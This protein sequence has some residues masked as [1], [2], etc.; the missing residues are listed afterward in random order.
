VAWRASKGSRRA[1]AWSCRRDALDDFRAAYLPR[2][3]L[4][5]GTDQALNTPSPR[6]ALLIFSLSSPIVRTCQQHA[7]AAFRLPIQRVSPTRSAS[8]PDRSTKLRHSR[9]PS[10][11]GADSL[12]RWL[13]QGRA[14]DSGRSSGHEASALGGETRGLAGGQR[15]ESKRSGSEGAAARA[16]RA[17]IGRRVAAHW[18]GMADQIKAQFVEP[19]LLLPAEQLPAGVQWLYELKLDGFRAEAIKSGGRVHLRSRNNKDFNTKYPVIV[20]ALASMPDETVIDGELVASDASGRPSFSALQNYSPGETRLFYYAFDVMTLKGQ[21]VMTEPLAARRELLQSQVLVG[22]DEPI[23]ESSELVAS[24]PDLIESVKAHGLEGLVAKRRDSPYEPGLRHGA[25][26]KMRVNRGQEF[27][28]AGYTLG[29]K[30]FDAIIFGYYDGENLVYAGRTRSGFTPSSRSQL[31][32]RFQGLAVE[33]C[34]FVNLPEAT[35]GRWG[36]GLTAERMKECRWLK[37]LLVGRFEFVE[38]TPDNHLRHS[39]FMM[40][41]EDVRPRDVKREA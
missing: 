33:I 10:S 14:D 32:K 2:A 37:P 19:M 7:I 8:R 34:P 28:I 1:S 25:W 21:G 3:V 6:A 26:Q 16:C 38:W 22:L 18:Y 39:R 9:W 36:E 27:V 40:L 23:R 5:L 17:R 41:R 12:R 13:A 4:Y 15:K 20:Q 11:E 29:P 35:D 30:S 31:F 24:L